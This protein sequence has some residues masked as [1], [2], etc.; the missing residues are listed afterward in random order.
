M[1]A[2]LSLEASLAFCATGLE[3]ALGRDDVQASLSN[4]C[5]G[6][7][8]MQS[9][10]ASAQPLL[11]DRITHCAKAPPLNRLAC[12]YYA[13]RDEWRTCACCSELPEC[14]SQ[15]CGEAECRVD[16]AED[17]AGGA[18]VSSALLGLCAGL[19]DG[20]RQACLYGAASSAMFPLD[21]FRHVEATV[22]FCEDVP[23]GRDREAC[24]DGLVFR[25]SKNFATAAD[26]QICPRLASKDDR[27]FCFGVAHIG[28]YSLEKEAT[29]QAYAV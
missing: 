7:V 1:L 9:G 18:A 27:D 16:A 26:T 25:A 12:F 13:L 14:P 8:W 20:P 22:A 5:S 4:Y 3:G 24:I 19:A 29:F 17:A 28:Q 2:G 6:G 15:H 23:V 10:N 11:T 21:A